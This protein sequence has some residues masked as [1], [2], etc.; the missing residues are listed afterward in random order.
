MRIINCFTAELI[1]MQRVLSAIFTLIFS[2]LAFF[3]F[4]QDT[5]KITS[6]D[7]GLLGLTTAKVPKEYTISSVKITGLTTLDT[8]IVKSISGLQVGDKVMIPGGDA[9]SKAITNL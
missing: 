4:T 7:P 1:N 9:F 5:S 2:A 3:A 6:V 8:S